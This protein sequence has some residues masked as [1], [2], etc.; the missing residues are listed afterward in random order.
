[1]TDNKDHV[2][3]IRIVHPDERITS[4]IITE[5]ELPNIIGKR[6]LEIEK[7]GH[8]FTDIGGLDDP[9]L[10]AKKELLDKK[11]PNIIYRSYPNGNVE[12]WSCNEMALDIT[13]RNLLEKSIKKK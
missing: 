4:N 1:M 5:Y 6:A 8:V 7:G 3:Y 13:T 10:I 12:K 2:E 9:E 11:N